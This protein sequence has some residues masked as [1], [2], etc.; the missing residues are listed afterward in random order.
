M[1]LI[2]KI[3]VLGRLVRE[4]KGQAL[5]FTALVLTT[6]MGVTGVAVDAG[7]GYYAYQ[8]L[9]ASTNAAALAGAAGLPIQG[10][11]Q[12][13]AQ[14]Y[15]SAT[16]YNGYN[17]NGVMSNVQTSVVFGCNTTV[18]TDFYAPC[19]NSSST[20]NGG[21]LVNEIQVTQT[22]QVPTW[23]GP[24]FGM[25]TFNIQATSAASMKGGTPTPYNIAII[26][27][28]TAS[29]QG[30]DNGAGAGLNCT[31]QITC[32]ELGVQTFLNDLIPG[33]SAAPIDLVTLYVFPG[34]T[35]AS[36]KN[37]Y[38]CNGSSPSIVPY[39]FQSYNAGP[40][41][42]S[43]PSGDTYN[44]L[45]NS[46]TGAT[47][48]S[49]DY[50]TSAT[51]ALNTSSDIVKAVGGSSGCGATAPGGEG[52]YYAQVIYQAQADLAAEQATNHN[53]NMMIILSD[54]DATACN[55]QISTVLTERQT[56]CGSYQIYAA[57][58][59]SITGAY[60]AVTDSAPCASPYSGQPIDGTEAGFVLNGTDFLIQ[61]A[62][63][64]TA[65]YP[66][67]LGECGQAVGAAQYASS[68]G[69]TV[70]TVGY[71][72]EMSGCTTD[73]YYTDDGNFP[74]YGA[75][76]WPNSGSTAPC[77]A[78][79]AMA[80]GPSDFFSDDVDGCAA[81]DVNNL[82]DTTLKKIF[83]K[84]GANLTSARLVPNS[85]FTPVS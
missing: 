73:Q 34:A 2:Y 20:G 59:R 35:A 6:F 18:A 14:N 80:T 53:G 21:S 16:T 44:V 65:T 15:G 62:G 43:L 19:E 55:P 36:M 37:D 54:G 76:A 30:N 85:Y 32:A 79:G 38:A 57:N 17:V 33:T 25:S 3:P 64:L 67:A 70:Y 48:W 5:V 51:S 24:L 72:S 68:K 78:L 71:G 60:G 4:D 52:T 47:T 49:S 82:D 84:I 11:A 1:K 12:T 22:A 61:P 29:M 28:T 56:A 74:T 58:C 50:K 23:I 31:T 46:S 40:T 81:T 69:T 77:Y 10:T 45:A 13:Y 39:Q 42:S 63:Y 7:K 8:M 83:M 26:L 9:N 75:N 27:D 41:T 66:S